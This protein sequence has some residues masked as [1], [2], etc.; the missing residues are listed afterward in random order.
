MAADGI[1]LQTFPAMPPTEPIDLRSASSP[2][3]GIPQ[4][5]AVASLWLLTAGWGAAAT[6]VRLDETTYQTEHCLFVVDSSV[7]W[8]TPSMCSGVPSSSKPIWNRS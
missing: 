8:A 1:E 7:T 6:L 3:R 4:L 2:A 5:L